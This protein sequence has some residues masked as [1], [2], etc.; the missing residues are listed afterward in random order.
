MKYMNT[1]IFWSI[2]IFQSIFQSR[3][4]TLLSFLCPWATALTIPNVLLSHALHHLPH[5]HSFL[6]CNKLHHVPECHLSPLL[7]TNTIH[8]LAHC[9][10][11]P[12]QSEHLVPLQLRFPLKLS[13]S[14]KHPHC[15]CVF[16]KWFLLR[17]I[18]RNPQPCSFQSLIIWFLSS[19]CVV[20]SILQCLFGSACLSGL[21]NIC[22][23][24]NDGISQVHMLKAKP[25][26]HNG[27]SSGLAGR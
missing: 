12:I 4:G 19:F 27:F 1:L 13:P 6:Q 20:S 3:R 17:K 26:Q 18:Y 9:I 21:H 16:L 10:H 14:S 23:G 2:W 22:F 11:G 24:F 7:S 5:G 8:C 15:V 25:L